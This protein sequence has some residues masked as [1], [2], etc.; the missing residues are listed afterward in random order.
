MY[1]QVLHLALFIAKFLLRIQ[2][3]RF[4]FKLAKSS[5]NMMQRLQSGG[6]FWPV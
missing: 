5:Y 2:N 3:Y 6:N 1:V 4:V